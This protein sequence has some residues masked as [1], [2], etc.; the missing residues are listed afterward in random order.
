MRDLNDLQYFALVVEHGGYAAA[1]RAS[2][3]SKSRLS[4][5]VA[6]LEEQLGVRLIQRSTRRFAVTEV[7]NDVYRQARGI[8]D[9]AQEL[10]DRVEQVIS[11]PRGVVR[12]S[13]PSSIAQVHLSELLPK[14]RAEYPDI[15]VVLQVTNR[16]VDLINEQLDIAMRVR[17][18][19]EGGADFVVREFGTT[20]ELLVASP[21]YLATAPAL[22][23]PEDLQQHAT[24]VNSA[25]ETQHQWE[26]HGP[27]QEVRR[28][29]LKPVIA[30][31]DFSMLL[32]LAV[33]GAGVTMLPETVC[34]QHVR[35]KELRIVLPDWNLPQGIAHMVY[36]SRRGVLPAVR[37]MI[38]FLARE[39]PL[40]WAQQ[41]VDCGE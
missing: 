15:R 28:I 20:R 18:R 21:E 41:R 23:T 29:P 26:L 19:I 8:L 4:R 39:M 10:R 12:M 34:H 22:N 6:D 25:D 3:I 14:F 35:D 9:Q 31:S 7:G 32:R 17:T 11:A 40:L 27:G 36:P 37:A 13:V 33:N 30:G 16:R 38:D 24:L 2:G 1:E 5:R